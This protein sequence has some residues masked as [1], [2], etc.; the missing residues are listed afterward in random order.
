MPDRVLNGSWP[1]T[2]RLALLDKDV[3]IAVGL[4][5]ETGVEGPLLHLVS[6]AVP[7][8][9]GPARGGALTTW[10]PIRLMNDRQGWRSGDEALAGRAARRDN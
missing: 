2:F 8:G 6:A 10:K 4:L 1:S 3:R 9:A 7:R 5:E